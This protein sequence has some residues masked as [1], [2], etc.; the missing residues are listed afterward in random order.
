M[1]D[2]TKCTT[3]TTLTNTNKSDKKKAKDKP[4]KKETVIDLTADTEEQ[5]HALFR[6]LY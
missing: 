6:L 3:K 5:R 1:D 2:S 4:I